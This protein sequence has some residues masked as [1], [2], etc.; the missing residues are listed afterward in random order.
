M[1]RNFEEVLAKAKSMEGTKI[2]VAAAAD[3]EVLEAVKEASELGLADFIL[4]GDKTKI[5]EIAASINLDLS[6][7]TVVDEPN[8]VASARKAVEFV[9]TKQAKTLMKGMIGT[10]DF[11]RAV[12]DKEI[13]LRTGKLLSHVAVI[14]S[15]KFDKLFYL[16]DGAM[17]VAPTLQDK[18]QI[19]QNAVDVAHK[20]DNPVPKVACIG[21]VEV[22]NPNMQPTV[23]AAL[24]AKMSDRKQ[25]KGCV[26]DGPFGLDNAISQEA[27]THKGVAGPVAGDAD[28]ILCPNI[29]VGNAMYKT[30]VY[31]ADVEV[32]A[33][34]S[35]AAAPIV[36]TSRAD[37]PRTKL[38]S[39]ATSIVVAG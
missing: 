26:V 12:L 8:V 9:S 2:S 31:F 37:S 13:G 25:I 34:I 14:K 5:E 27:A 32:G 22:V 28:I 20:L 17:C 23:D 33:I 29:E 11:L 15:P 19:I 6:K 36:L 7:Q 4:V 1:Y 38:L 3:L 35:G 39:I 16:T 10:A 21:A 30:L 18:V 24:L